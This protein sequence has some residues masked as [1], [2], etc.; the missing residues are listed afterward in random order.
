MP[1]QTK[2]LVFLLGGL[3]STKITFRPMVADLEASG[4]QPIVVDT[5]TVSSNDER[6]VALRNTIRNIFIE[7]NGENFAIIGQSAGGLAALRFAQ[8]EYKDP[9]LR[10]LVLCSPAIPRLK[11]FPLLFA[12]P[13]LMWVLLKYLP[14]ILSRRNIKFNPIDL[15]RLNSPLLC[16]MGRM[17]ELLANSGRIPALEA[18]ELAFYPP[19]LTNRF[20]TCPLTLVRGEEDKWIR[21]AINKKFFNLLQNSW[22]SHNVVWLTSGGGHLVLE[23]KMIRKSIIW[24]LQEA[25][26]F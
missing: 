7:K 25:F 15:R 9:H 16:G 13:T 8:A 20:P 2:H 5:S 18:R 12:T 22:G 11:R 10:A 21:N 24:R 19:K 23:D 26:H 4:F 17:C 14:Q 1:K 6:V 3:G